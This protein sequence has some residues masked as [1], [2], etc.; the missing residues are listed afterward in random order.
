MIVIDYDEK[1]RDTI[2]YLSALL[3]R[4]IKFT[5]EDFEE[6]RNFFRNNILDSDMMFY[7]SIDWLYLIGKV[8][9]IRKGVIICA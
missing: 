6:A 5:C 1:P 7:Y 9:E 3:Y 8:K 2:F 4:Y